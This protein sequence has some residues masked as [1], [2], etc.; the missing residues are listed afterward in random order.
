M[1]DILKLN[2]DFKIYLDASTQQIVSDLKDILYG[3]SV[4]YLE[5]KTESDIVAYFFEYEYDYLNVVCWAVDRAGNIITDTIILST[6]KNSKTDENS[7]WNAFIPES[8]WTKIADFHD[9]YEDDDFDDILD[10]YN[11]EK[12]ELFEKWFCNCWSQTVKE[13]GIKV[14]AYFSIHDTIFKTDLNTLEKIKDKQIE[15][16]F[17]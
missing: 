15:E 9:N 3:K 7:K 1:N 6:Q 5:D 2:K 10:E 12:Y 8:I 14:D 17:R 11:Q 4:V 16:R 13:T